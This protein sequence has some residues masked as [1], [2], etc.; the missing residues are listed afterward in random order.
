MSKNTQLRNDQSTDLLNLPA[1]L[2]V[3]VVPAVVA[4]VA[5]VFVVLVVLVV[6]VVFVVFVVSFVEIV[7]RTGRMMEEPTTHLSKPQAF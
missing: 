3:P 6:F 2:V 1:V 7:V 4:V 5:A